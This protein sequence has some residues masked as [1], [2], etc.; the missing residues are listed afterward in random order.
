[1]KQLLIS[2]W[3]R[4]WNKKVTWF[5]LCS[6]PILV[7]ISTPY[8]LNNNQTVNPS[9]PEYVVLG[10]FPVMGISEQLISICNLIVI[11]LI[12]SMV[13][14]EYN[15]GQ[16]R[17]ILLRAYSFSQIFIAKFIIAIITIALYL[18]TFFTF[19]YIIG[20]IFFKKTET[21]NLF[22]YNTPV[23]NVEAFTY[24][25]S[26]YI[27]VFLTLIAM[28]CV[29]LFISVIFRAPIIALGCGTGFLII[30]LMYPNI[31][32]EVSNNSNIE[33]YSITQIQ[34][35]GIT[36]MLKDSTYLINYVGVLI[37]YTILFF[38]LAYWIFIKKDRFL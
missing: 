24:N 3:V 16:L 15:T 5:I 8:Y 12:V 38:S 2:E 25:V 27:L 9:S 30:S 37:T 7:G 21:V 33:F 23:N 13:T 36:L 22:Y 17:F 34:W 1:M 26:Y 29:I 4:L 6:M 18:V 20:F 35:K 19:A 10:N 28:A 31:I 32:K 11:L 14:E